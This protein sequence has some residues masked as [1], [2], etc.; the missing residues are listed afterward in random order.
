[1]MKRN[2]TKMRL[3]I[4]LCA[5]LVVAPISAHAGVGDIIQLLTTITNTL[6]GEIG[7]VLGS[8]R[9]VNNA[10][11]NLQQQVVWP[12]TAINQAK[13]SVLQVR[14]QITGLANQV[15]AIEVSSATLTNPQQ[16]EAV[17]RNAQT[18]NLG[19]IQPAYLKIYGAVPSVT[20]AGSRDRNLIDIDDAMAAGSLKTASISS[21]ATEQML[22]VADSLEQQ[23]AVTSP[24]SAPLL[25]AQAQVANLQNQAFLQ[26]ML[27]AE[28]RQEA[29]RLAHDNAT[30]KSSAEANRNLR[31]N[32]QQIL[33]RP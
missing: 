27:A 1:M 17:L 12:V 7:K 10:R 6:K 23:S 16:L 19:G 20:G 3:A 29:A 24:G 22:G 25:T 32:M 9:Q 14:S 13:G 18:V 8:I 31:D 11:Q 33:R 28:L 26:K 21:Q 5:L 4:V 2:S 15:H 30:L